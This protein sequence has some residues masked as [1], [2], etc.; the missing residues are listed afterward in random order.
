MAKKKPAAKSNP[1]SSPKSHARNPAKNLADGT[2]PRQEAFVEEGEVLTTNQGLTLSDN[3]NSLKAGPRGPSLLEDFVLREKITSFDHERIPE[4]IVHARG[5]GAFGYFECTEDIR[6]FS[7]AGFLTEVGK[8]TPVLVRFSTVAGSRG[9]MDTAR[10]VRGFAVKFYTDEGNYDLVGN[11]IPVFFIQDAMKF[12]DLIHAAKPEQDVE[13]PQ[14]Q[15]AHDTFWDFIS[16]MP[17]SLHMVCW[18][19]S[20]RA[21]P[22]SFRMMEGFGV[23][24][25]RLVNAQGVATFVKFH[26]KPVLGVHSL[27]WEESQ[28]LGGLDPD[29]H[30]KDLF[31]AIKN[32]AFPEW[33]LG[34]QLIPE[35]DEFK[36]PFDLLD[37]TKLVPEELVP[38]RKIGRLVL[39]RNPD[40]YFAEIEQAAFHPGHLVPGI[41]L[42][43]DPLLQG[44]LFSYTDTQLTRLGGPNFHE[45]PVNR[46]LAPVNNNQRDGF[47]RQLIPKGKVAYEPNS[48]RGG[49]PFHAGADMKSF[50]HHDERISAPKVRARSSSFGD[51]ISQ[52]KLF[53]DSQSPVEQIHIKNAFSFE[54]S[55]VKSPEVRARMC[56]LLMFVNADLAKEVSQN[57]GSKLPAKPTMPPNAADP[58]NNIVPPNRSLEAAEEADVRLKPKV[59]L[60]KTS[61]SLG[62]V[63]NNPKYVRSRLVAMLVTP[64]SDAKAVAAFKAAMT[65][66]GVQCEAVQP[67]ISLNKDN[68]NDPAVEQC[69]STTP[70]HRYDG[71]MV[72]SGPKDYAVPKDLGCALRFVGQAFKHCKTIGAAGS[73]AL[74]VSQATMDMDDGAPGM[75]SAGKDVS[76]LAKDFITALAEHRHWEREAMVESM[77][78]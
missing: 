69:I 58:D 24:T 21:I 74:L 2:P 8:K 44:R 75:V 67:Q 49:C 36:F 25:F 42:T 34:V 19:M 76:K 48:L 14:A 77:P 37:P 65:K 57:V 15:T 33:E 46:P 11:N 26:W 29:Y 38:V 71:V 78:F 9:S 13:I 66:A 68:E 32:G 63:A 43:N 20:D 47:G 28:Q 18:A 54:L 56:E 45:L 53:F 31:E 30:R 7:A 55:K 12:P 39:N 22:R 60:P 70:S 6:K 50:V 61:K 1:K 73:G 40:N 17:E 23:H 72:F 41:D 62:I 5:A 27:P 64:K 16:L 59:A 10:D 35:A 3:H 52:A 4:R 51:H